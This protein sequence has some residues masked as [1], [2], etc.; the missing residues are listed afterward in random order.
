[1]RP[2]G[3]AALELELQTEGYQKGTPT[4]DAALLQR[5]VERCQEQ[6]GVPSCRECGYFD[7]CETAKDFLVHLRYKQE[8][9]A[10]KELVVQDKLPDWLFPPEIKA[11]GAGEDRGDDALPRRPGPSR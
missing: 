6:K 1:M 4:F 9:Q 10:D 3:V 7:H 2:A 8:P 5:K 11:H